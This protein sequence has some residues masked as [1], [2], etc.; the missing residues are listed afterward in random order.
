MTP[1]NLNDLY[2]HQ[3]RDL[4]SAEKQL[5]DALPDMIEKSNHPDLK[6]AFEEHL[7]ETKTQKNRLERVFDSLGESPSGETC[8]AMKGLIKEAN[9]IISDTSSWLGS[10][11]PDEVR[12]AG[13]I[14]AAQRVEHYE[15]AGYGT[16][17]T[18]ADRL[19]R[20]DEHSLLSETLEEEKQADSKLNTIA[21]EIVNPQAAGA[22]S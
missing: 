16:V 11:S 14:A 21:E 1:K 18:Y 20:S 7:N 17:C 6:R 2:I 3:L 10:D 22:S 8:Q 4:Y 9:D 13:L 15:M 5:I 19:G 12:D